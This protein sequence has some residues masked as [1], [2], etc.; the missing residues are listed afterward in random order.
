MERYL[1]KLIIFNFFAGIFA[2]FFNFL[3][4][5]SLVFAQNLKPFSSRGSAEVIR[6]SDVLGGDEFDALGQN[7]KNERADRNDRK[8][9][10]RRVGLL[11]RFRELIFGN[12]SDF[13]DEEDSR[14]NSN[15]GENS[16]SNTN[17]NRARPVSPPQPIIPPK[18]I[19]VRPNDDFKPD[20]PTMSNSGTSAEELPTRATSIPTA[21]NRNVRDNN[22]VLLDGG[23]DNNSLERL[24]G[25]REGFFGAQNVV[26]R[27]GV[28][29]YPDVRRSRVDDDYYSPVPQPRD[30]SGYRDD[31]YSES[32]ANT[33]TNTRVERRVNPFNSYNAWDRSQNEYQS[34]PSYADA[35]N[36]NYAETQ[37]S[38]TKLYSQNDNSY[39]VSGTRR[40]KIEE[41]WNRPAV[42]HP[43]GQS[44]TAS[45]HIANQFS[46]NQR[47]ELQ[48]H[49][50]RLTVSPQIEVETSGDSRVIVGRESKY[51]IRV[52]NRGGATAEQVVLNIEIPNW[53]KLHL[54]ELSTGV[55]EFKKENAKSGSRDYVWTVGNLDPNRE[56]LLE[57]LLIPQER[58][59]IDLQVRYDFQKPFTKTTIVVE[60]A[61]LEME[62]QG[63]DEIMWGTEVSY[64]LL[65]RNIGSGDAE[66][67]KLELM[68]TGS[69]NKECTL[70]LIKAGEEKSIVVDVWAGKQQ[71]SVEININAKGAYDVNA[72]VSKKVT[73]LRPEVTMF[74]ETADTQFVGAPAEVLVKIKNSGNAEA[75]NLDLVV[76]IPVGTKYISS[77]NGGEL[78]PQNL[79]KWNIDS[80]PI[81]GEFLA[82]VVCSPNREGVC[83][84][85]TVLKDKEDSVA[86][87][88]SVF[89]AE[90]I[91]DLRMVV[92]APNGPIEVGQDAVFLINVTNRGTKLASD[93]G[94]FVYCSGG[95]KPVS[96]LGDK[97]KIDDGVVEFDLIP[98]VSAGQ[99]VV[100]KVVTKA[101]YGGT[102]KIRA[103][104]MSPY[105]ADVAAGKVEPQ[106][107]LLSEQTLN[108][109]QRRGVISQ[110][111]T[112]N[113]TTPKTDNTTLPS[114]QPQPKTQQT[115][116]P[117]TTTEPS[118][119]D[120]FPTN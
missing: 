48:S 11:G 20:A 4:F 87:C 91:S 51:R 19:T 89:T 77:T 56:E 30:R 44:A 3:I 52:S 29:E 16:G 120:P 92:E 54:S 93:V 26:V 84:I 39:G 43:V 62:L 21:R 60:E 81:N 28:D 86:Q 66:K 22:S 33:S 106:T 76:T 63:P 112:N 18:P 64:L 15:A 68:E 53:L 41:D 31:S 101:E 109:Y 90:A 42:P 27:D 61:V 104:L 107:R 12:E 14:T 85:E 45:P 37:Y 55:T 71:K 13:E 114:P 65:V 1:T 99:T 100:M 118:I 34:N 88:T 74:V 58:K 72:N 67:V 98:A 117:K 108:F 111:Q 113:N 75:K 82:S 36:P 35:T 32:R 79:V 83:K 10:T 9:S 97:S 25:M 80:L 46:G 115:P 17:N 6:F 38:T 69:K 94:L 95:L 73:I 110:K 102:H 5:D 116:K 47:Q 59:V 96:T 49:E 23:G 40:A 24:K 70:P 105:T 2:L 119:F 103:E 7:D 50:R 57:L 8:E 78:T